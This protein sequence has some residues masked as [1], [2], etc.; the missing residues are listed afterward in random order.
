M[1]I[2][3]LIKALATRGSAIGLSM[4]SM[5]MIS[6]YLGAELSGLY[7]FGVTTAIIISSIAKLGFDMALMK[8]IAHEKASNNHITKISDYELIVLTVS[9]C[10]TLLAIIGSYAFSKNDMHSN[11]FNIILILIMASPFLALIS[12]IS[13][14]LQGIG[15]VYSSTAIL[16]APAIIPLLP[17]A[18]RLD[19]TNIL[20]IAWSFLIGAIFTYGASKLHLRNKIGKPKTSHQKRPK[21]RFEFSRIQDHWPF[22]TFSIAAIIQAKVHIYIL[23]AHSLYDQ[24]AIFNICERVSTIVAFALAAG[25]SFF[26]QKFQYYST[27]NELYKAQKLGESLTSIVTFI[28]GIAAAIIIIFSDEILGIAGSDFQPGKKTLMILAISQLICVAT[29]PVGYIL[30]ALDEQRSLALATVVS[31]TLGISLSYF[32][33]PKLGSLGASLSLSISLIVQNIVCSYLL[34]KRKNMIII[35]FLGQLFK[36]QI[37]HKPKYQDPR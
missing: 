30:I 24:V 35:P 31:L 18:I 20:D 1:L 15:S 7:V 8:K 3:K 26:A 21:F 17:I 34:F 33:S 22:I 12:L 13:G 2:S 23:S 14:A 10:L 29:G 9:A 11:H 6:K 36:S 27:R 25:N 28:G 19:N 5:F 32:L 37:T 4:I 16:S